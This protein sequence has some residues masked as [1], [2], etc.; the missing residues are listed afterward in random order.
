[1][2]CFFFVLLWVDLQDLMCP[3]SVYKENNYHELPLNVEDSAW[4]I[5]PHS[6]FDSVSFQNTLIP[7]PFKDY[8]TNP[9]FGFPFICIAAEFI[10]NSRIVACQVF[11]EIY[12][13]GIQ[14]REI[15][16]CFMF[17]LKNQEILAIKWMLAGVH[18]TVGCV[19]CRF[20]ETKSTLGKR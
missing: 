14:L 2:V 16:T 5:L 3:L 4:F 10:C 11:V 20:M 8:I 15:P 12:V 19:L 6:F 17:F 7:V 1:M 13:L 18:N 9:F